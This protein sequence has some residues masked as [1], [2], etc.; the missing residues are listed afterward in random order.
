MIEPIGDK[1]L[2]DP[3][4]VEEITSGGIFLPDSSR[5]VPDKGKIISVGEAVE[6]E[7]LKEGVIVFF[8]KNSGTSVRDNEHEYIILPVQE[9]V[10]IQR[11]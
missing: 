2:V 10:G 3:I 9:I 5:A 6:E 4:P 1:L 8:R 11:D 7:K